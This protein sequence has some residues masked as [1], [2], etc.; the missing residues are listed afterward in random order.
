M[1]RLVR[2]SWAEYFFVILRTDLQTNR[3][4]L[5]AA[6]TFVAVGANR[7]STS[8]YGTVRRIFSPCPRAVHSIS[9][10]RS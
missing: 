8:V 2:V 3:R 1:E 6:Q 4:C 7:E 5:G 10:R 9:L